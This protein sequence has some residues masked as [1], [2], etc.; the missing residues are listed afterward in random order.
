MAFQTPITLFEALQHIDQ[1]RY[2]LPALQREFVWKP[3]QITRLF[4][5][6]M[7]GYPIGSFLFWKL[8]G[9]SA[10]EYKFYEFIKNYN[11]LNNRYCQ[12]FS[13]E[14]TSPELAVL[15]GQQRLTAC[16]IGL[17]GSYAQKRKYLKKN[18]AASY[19]IRYLFVDL[20]YEPGEDDDL[21]YRFEFLT[22]ADAKKKTTSNNE[23]W[24][25]VREILTHDKPHQTFRY[26]QEHNL[27]NSEAAF[28]IL[29]RLREL[30]FKD[31]AVAYYEEKD[32]SLDKVLNIFIRINSGGTP[33]SYSDLLLSLATT[34]WQTIDA[35][36]AINELVDELSTYG[37][38][39]PIRFTKDF[40][41]KTGL[42]LTGRP[43]V[44]F[45]AQNF[46]S[47]NMRL[48]ERSFDAIAQA[49]RLTAALVESFGL[50]GRH[51]TSL[52]TL[53]PIAHYIYKK[54]YGDAFLTQRTHR[55]ERKE[56]RYWMMR[57]LIGNSW[58]GGNV[59]SMLLS[60][61]DEIDRSGVFD[62]EALLK[63]MN[64][65]GIN[66]FFDAQALRQLV[67]EVH[68]KD[69][70]ALLLLTLLYDFIQLDTHQFHIDHV[71]PRALTNRNRLVREHGL[72]SQQEESFKARVNVLPNLW[73]LQGTQN[74]EKS[75]QLPLAW[76]EEHHA[77]AATRALLMDSYHLQE[78]PETPGDFDA[79]FEARAERM[80]HALCTI[81]QVPYAAVEA[82]A[83]P[84][85]LE[86][87]SLM[88]GSVVL[89]EERPAAG[90]DV[91]DM[92]RWSKELFELLDTQWHP[93]ARALAGYGVSEPSLIETELQQQGVVT[94]A[95]ALLSWERTASD[96]PSLNERLDLVDF[97]VPA[98][99]HFDSALLLSLRD[100][101]D[102]EVLA[103]RIQQFLE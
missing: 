83:A 36:K 27:T 20:L 25:R 19:P 88:E 82:T 61:R 31:N 99:P 97:S 12:E 76:L 16:Y 95:R 87:D 51:I 15:D 55:E 38:E 10:K 86:E 32:P 9:D 34:Q 85:T 50:G 72:S 64:A 93:L 4:D 40:V 46:T 73:L 5:S 29:E 17:Y 3:Q 39:A 58:S 22:E 75:A 28:P 68:Y 6:L 2:V 70:R 24:F 48:M 62:A 79:F 69:R 74:L 1:R 81:F 98:T 94:E 100:E 23:H 90:E 11:E 53:L 37:V 103:Q 60:L 84:Q 54:S 14:T 89:D 41:L 18:D 8:D 56:I 71:F 13:S 44:K 21:A 57:T 26:L 102:L 66:T 49:L 63:R 91:V 77:D 47:E 101:P 92:A 33:L 30:I 42:M 45:Q 80:V 67:N 43:S 7:R 78:L 52:N 59:D 96:D 65:Q 35:R